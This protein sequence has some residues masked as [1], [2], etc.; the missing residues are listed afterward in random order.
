MLRITESIN[1]STILSGLGRILCFNLVWEA[2]AMCSSV[3]CAHTPLRGCYGQCAFGIFFSAHTLPPPTMC[4]AVACAHMSAFLF[5]V[6]PFAVLFSAEDWTI[7]RLM[8]VSWHLTCGYPYVAVLFY[9]CLHLACG[10]AFV[11][12][13]I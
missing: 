13:P 2:A 9:I 7:F 12:F 1:L 8:S 11:G 5:E 10:K 3:A 6:A 4:S